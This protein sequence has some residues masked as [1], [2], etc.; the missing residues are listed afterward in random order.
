[1]LKNSETFSVQT[2]MLEEFYVCIYLGLS[3][4][5]KVPGPGIKPEVLQ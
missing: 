5:M 3:R 4:S 1:M 2:F